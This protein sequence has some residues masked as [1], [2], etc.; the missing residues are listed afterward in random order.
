MPTTVNSYTANAYARSLLELGNEQNQ[1]D[2]LGREMAEL[3]EIL[4]ANPSFG[5]FLSDPGIG[6]GE[7]V[8]AIERIFRGRVSPLLWN[9]LGV[10]NA[11]GRIGQ[12]GQVAE[13]YDAL[14][15]EQRGIIEVDVTVAQRLDAAQL[16]QVRQR[17]SQALGKTAVVHQYVDEAIIGGMIL[18][19]EDK[20][21]DTS[22]RYQLQ[23][24]RQRLLTSRRK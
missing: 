17:V 7:R 6:E 10:L 22:V 2:A 5:A 14:L 23:A 15:E 9:F 11:H 24:M 1:T 18:R 19:V 13:A 12:L 4:A 16:E 21:I 3:R 8:A 20:L